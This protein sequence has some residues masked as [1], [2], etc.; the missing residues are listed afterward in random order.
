MAQPLHVADSTKEL[1]ES[2]GLAISD[3]GKKGRGVIATKAFSCGDV[4]LH[5]KGFYAENMEKLTDLLLAS[6]EGRDAAA[7]MYAGSLHHLQDSGNVSH[8]L[9]S[10]TEE[11]W[12]DMYAKVR[13]NCFRLDGSSLL[14]HMALVNHSCRPN[15]A[16]VWMEPFEECKVALVVVSDNIMEGEEVVHCYDSALFYMP[17]GERRRYLMGAWNFLCKCARCDAEEDASEEEVPDEI[18]DGSMEQL[19]SQEEPNLRN[20]RL[21]LQRQDA[22]NLP[23]LDFKVRRQLFA[24]QLTA[25]GSLLPPLHPALRD[26]YQSLSPLCNSSP[27]AEHCEQMCKFYDCL[28]KEGNAV[29]ERCGS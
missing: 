29:W 19:T 17:T 14:P 13:Y 12:R 7:H 23:A 22:L 20:L 5:E 10:V 9:D 28:C 3:F 4:L 11:E 18:D 6:K 1:F 25:A 2:A 15:A 21:F 26:L 8:N 27:Y 24:T 16:L